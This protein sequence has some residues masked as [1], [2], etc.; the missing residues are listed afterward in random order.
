VRLGGVSR[1]VVD[2]ALC[3]VVLMP[4]A[5]VAI[6]SGTPVPPGLTPIG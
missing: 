6:T 4:S 2:R 5:D 1:A 3:P